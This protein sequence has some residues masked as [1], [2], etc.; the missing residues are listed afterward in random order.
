MTAW[1]FRTAWPHSREIFA[2]LVTGPAH[3]SAT[4]GSHLQTSLVL[5]VA[6]ALLD[7]FA[8]VAVAFAAKSCSRINR[9][10]RNRR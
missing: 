7:A 4:P 8:G 6:G 3:H 2:V 9:R 5:S 1:L 10:I